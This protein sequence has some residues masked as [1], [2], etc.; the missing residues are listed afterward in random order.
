VHARVIDDFLTKESGHLDDVLAKDYVSTGEWAPREVLGEDARKW[1]NKKI[2][3]LSTLRSEKEPWWLG[4]MAVSLASAFIDFYRAVSDPQYKAAFDKAADSAFQ[5]RRDFDGWI[6]AGA[7][8][9]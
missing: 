3:H 7:D 5:M 2:A 9:S 1:I 4:E 6:E 8:H